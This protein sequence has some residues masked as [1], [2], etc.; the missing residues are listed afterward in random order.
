MV[1][2][3]PEQ[4]APSVTRGV[5]RPVVLLQAHDRPRPPFVSVGGTPGPQAPDHQA[6]A[7]RRDARWPHEVEGPVVRAVLAAA[8]LSRGPVPADRPRSA[9]ATRLRPVAAIRSHRLVA[10]LVM[11]FLDGQESCAWCSTAQPPA[12]FHRA[13]PTGKSGHGFMARHLTAASSGAADGPA[14]A[15]PA[16][17]AAGEPRTPG[18]LQSCSRACFPAD[19]PRARR[20]STAGARANCPWNRVSVRLVDRRRFHPKLAAA[21]RGPAALLT[22][23]PRYQS[24]RLRPAVRPKRPAAALSGRCGRRR[25]SAFGP[26][27]KGNGQVLFEE[28]RRIAAASPPGPR[29]APSR[30]AAAHSGCGP[31]RG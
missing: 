21:A 18:R 11:C 23:E 7:T 19:R 12:A 29:P 24:E 27:W 30:S 31:Q 26:P 3:A 14:P 8:S 2:A 6:T 13:E 9:A 28:P 1:A 16:S 25:R 10:L 15:R 4:T 22:S 5:P 17:A 20:L